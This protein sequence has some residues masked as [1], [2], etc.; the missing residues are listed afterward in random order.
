[1][2]RIASLGRSY[3]TVIGCQAIAAIAA[4]A[5]LR[6]LAKYVDPET[7]G[8]YSLYQ[9]VVA[10]GALFLVSWPNAALLRFGREEWVRDG[11]VG[12]T[13]GARALLFAACAAVAVTLAWTFDHLL[14]AFL[15]VE[16][17]PF[18]WIAAGVI[19]T[20]AAELAIYLNQAIGRTEV[21]GYSPA[22]TRVGFLLGIV[23][24]PFM[25]APPGWTYLAGW[26]IGSTAAAGAFAFATMPRASWS[27]LRVDSPTVVT[28]LKYS[29]TLPFAAI[30][31]YVVSWIDTWVIRELRGVGSVGVYTWA[32]QVTAI[33]S[34][35]FAPIAV[36]LT[37]RVIDARLRHDVASIKRYVDA[38]LPAAIIL[39]IVTAGLYA[40]VSPMMDWIASPAYAPA[41]P[42]ILILLAA[43]PFQ[44]IAYLVTPLANAYERLL[45]RIVLVSAGIAVMN[46]IGDV[47]L[48]SRLGIS[49]AAIA[50]TVAFTIGGILLIVVIRSE[51]IEFGPLWRYALP[52]FILSPAAAVLVWLGPARGALLIMATLLTLLASVA[53]S[54]RLVRGGQPGLTPVRRLLALGRALA[55]VEAAPA[56]YRESA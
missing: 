31:T 3:L 20:P 51:G 50:T 19:V 37:P 8:R 55:L 26:L 56:S 2:T 40:V 54:A 32:Y 6:W 10:A 14:R 22:I 15:H 16:H 29:W 35:A 11:R 53:L 18:L 46:A 24:I 39:S 1:V 13:L 30:S 25:A 48:V 5:A 33:A 52:T 4:I 27:G 12:V 45:P 7:F 28:L 47:V 49:G 17:S 41:Y 34:L 23:I 21:Y 44:L 43:L 38:I 36:V 9:S 42:V